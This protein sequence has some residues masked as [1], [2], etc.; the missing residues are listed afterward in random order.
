MVSVS[1]L[2][3]KAEKVL[4]EQESHMN[5]VSLRYCPF[6]RQ[7]MDAWDRDR[8]FLQWCRHSVLYMLLKMT[9]HIQ[10]MGI[11]LQSPEESWRD[12]ELSEAIFELPICSG[13]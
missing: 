1:S 8:H 12:C 5:S 10:G 7:L 13:E 4:H 2:I 6:L 11:S 3:Y 9:S